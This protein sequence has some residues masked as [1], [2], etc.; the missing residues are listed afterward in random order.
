MEMVIY[1][2]PLLVAS[3]AGIVNETVDKIMLKRMLFDTYGEIAANEQVGI[4]GACYKISIIVTLFVQAFRYAA[5]PFFFSEEKRENSK[6][7]YARVLKYFVIVVSIIFLGVMLYLDIIK[8]FIRNEDFW[9][10]LGVVPILLMANICLGIF[11]N[12]SVWYKLSGKTK[13]GA[14]ISGIGAIITLVLNY[15]WIPLYGYMGSAWATL[16]C[17]ASMAILSYVIGQKHYTIHYPL[18]TILLYLFSALLLYFISELISLDDSALRYLV[19]S[20]IFVAFI[21]VIYRIEK[22]KKVIT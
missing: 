9:V 21:T 20:L 3:L 22:P 5:E 10:G 8:H 6:E 17:Y 19:H 14:Y 15:W 2:S 11:Y 13:Y 1:G 7:S 18:K 16:C 12:L 4:Y